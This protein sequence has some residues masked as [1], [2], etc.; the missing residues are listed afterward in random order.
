MQFSG[1]SDSRDI[2]TEILTICKATTGKYSLKSIARRV[3]LGID[4]FLE[5]G[6]EIAGIKVD[7]I[8][9]TSAPLGTQTITLGTNAYK[10]AS[11][12]GSAT[13]FTKLEILDSGSR[14]FE[15]IEDSAIEINFNQDYS[16]SITGTP[17][18]FLR[19]GD[20][21]YL[22]PT[23]NYTLAAAL[24]A[25]IERPAIYV[26]STDTTFQPGIPP[27]FHEWLCQY[28]SQKYLEE[29]EMSNVQSNYQH[30]LDGEARIREYFSRIRQGIGT[31]AKGLNQNNR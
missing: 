15:L 17:T 16:T 4:R 14:S 19:L 6:H 25:M 7:D 11:F 27:Q 5:I 24:K 2:V 20:F 3:N 23:P 18:N 31:T 8:N 10:I 29:N 12:N 30:I 22:R 13:N 9:R 26:L 1:E 28:G 21:L